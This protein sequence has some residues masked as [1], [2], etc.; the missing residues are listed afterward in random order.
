MSKKNKYFF[1]FVLTIFFLHILFSIFFEL[2]KISG[3]SMYPTL[4]DGEIEISIK[5]E[6]KEIKRGDIVNI[7]SDIEKES[8]VKR[9]IAFEGEVVEIKEDGVYIDGKLLDEPYISKNVPSYDVGYKTTVPKGCVF[10][11]GDNRH[12]SKDSRE[13]GCIKIEEI[14]SILVFHF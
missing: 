4:K 10:V 12:N 5:S 9:V 1:S 3:N 13:I 8:I 6:Y 7:S 11:L 2:G 14:R